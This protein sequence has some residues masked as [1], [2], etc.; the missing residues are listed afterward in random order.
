MKIKHRICILVY[1]RPF[2]GNSDY[3][4]YKCNYLFGFIP[5]WTKLKTFK[6]TK[7][8]EV[9]KYAD[10]LAKQEYPHILEIKCKN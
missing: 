10:E 5:Y 7:F 4:V 8:N 1:N 9:Y 2:I 3:N 6:N